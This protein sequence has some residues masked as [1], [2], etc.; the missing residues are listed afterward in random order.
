MAGVVMALLWLVPAQAETRPSLN[1][2]GAT[3][4]IDM[5]SAAVQPDGTLSASTAHFGPVSRT[6]LSF[7]ITP[8]LSGSFRFLGIRDWNKVLCCAGVNQFETYYDRSF[9]LRYQIVD[10]GRYRPALAIGLQDF[11]GTGVIAGEYLVATK[12]VTPKV[13][14]SAGLGWGR[15]GSYHSIGSPFGDRPPL[16]VGKGGNF[17]FGQWFRGPAA[18]FAGLQWQIT[19]QWTAKAEYSSD[20]YHEEAARRGTFD[21][22]SPFNFGIEYQRNGSV[23]LGA[24]VMHGSE[25]GLAAHFSLNPKQRPGGGIANS[26]P[27]AVQPRP[28]RQA[29]PEAWSTAWL[30]QPG[31][32]DALRARLARR[33]AKDGV[34]VESV[35][36]DGSTAHVSIRNISVDA[37]AQAVGRTARALT[38]VAP[39]SV[40]TFVIVPRVDGMPVS[41]VVLRRADIEALEFDVEAGAK[42]L[43]RAQ[44]LPA[45][46]VLPGGYRDPAA[47]PKL[48]WSLGPTSRTRVFDQTAPF[49]IGVGLELA[50]RYE[51]APGLVLNGAVS[52]YLLST[53][54][55][56]PPLPTRG[57]LHPVRS[58]NYFYD[59]DGD[60]ALTSLALTAYRK[61]SPELYGRVSFGYLEQ[62]FGGVSTELL[63]LPTNRRWAIGAEVNYVAQRSPDQ[64]FGFSLPAAMYETDGCA[65]DLTT[66]A[67]GARGSYR[68]LTGHLSGYY[69][70]DSDFHV[71]VDVGRYLAGDLGATLALRREFANGWKVGAFVTKTNVSAE[72]FGSGSF[73]KGITVE[74][75]M[76]ALLGTPTPKKRTVIL[77]PFGRDGGR[78]L[79]VEGRLYDSVRGYRADGLTEQ[80]GRFW[81]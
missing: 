40:D 13:A 24:Y 31:T 50:G 76:A 27:D 2:Y 42:I 36:F 60:P 6:T 78:R 10:E 39:A 37:E 43:A 52:K 67:C 32:L 41:Q 16:E 45:P 21:R 28:S 25:I 63:W 22:S 68:I 9:D 38:K 8:R 81:K 59:R 77:R 58:A 33:L 55:D 1:L 44:I 65:P 74:V 62:M 23:R 46:A 3:G 57:R 11:V 70:F 61:L 34:Q 69:K 47:Y 29:D 54:D 73:D 75:P 17:N 15:L 4:L 12:H 26:A 30:D 35:R 5:P 20:V 72:D 79:E 53:L 56:R 18:P 7:Q 80:W 19:D 14:V 51:L 66:G 64:R 71:Q 48:S 49:K